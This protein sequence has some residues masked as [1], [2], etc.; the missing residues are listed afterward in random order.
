MNASNKTPYRNIEQA[1]YT[2]Y[3]LQGRGSVSNTNKFN[4]AYMFLDFNND[5]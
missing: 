2:K 5:C 1:I 3:I 4:F